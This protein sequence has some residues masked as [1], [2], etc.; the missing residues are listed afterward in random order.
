MRDHTLRIG[1]KHPDF[2]ARKLRANLVEMPAFLLSP[3]AKPA[4]LLAS[5]SYGAS[6]ARAD[7]IAGRRR[8]PHDGRP[9]S[10]NGL[11]G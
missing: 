10:V 4:K 1:H 3:T 8:A 9:R 6:H 5:T 11:K 7:H 2:V